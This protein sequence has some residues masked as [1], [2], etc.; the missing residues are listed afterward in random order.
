MKKKY[1]GTDGIRGRVGTEK[2]H[3]EF[4]MKLGWALGRVLNHTDHKKVIIG[5]DTRISGYMFESAL[6]AG[7]SAAGVDVRLIGPMPTPA[8][9]YLTQTFRANAGVVISASHNPYQD[10]GIKFFDSNG[11]KLPDEIE[12]AIEAEMAKPFELQEPHLLGKASRINDANGRYIEFCKST[13]SSKLRLNGLKIVLDCANGATYKVAP[14]VFKE[15]GAQVVVIG[16]KP[17]GLNINHEC[18]S[19]HPEHL[20]AK[21]LACQADLGIAFDGDGDRVVM[22]DHQGQLINGDGV[23]YLIATD[24]HEQKRLQGGVVGT[25]MT[26]MALEVKFKELQIPFIRSN[27]GDRYVLAELKK[28][29]WIIGGETSGHIVCLDKTTTGDGI[30]AALQV[31]ANMVREQKSL[32][33]LM[34]EIQFYPQVLLNIKTVNASVL[35]ESADVMHVIEKHVNALEGRGRILV[36]PSGTEPLLRIL[37]E[38]PNEA[39]LIER[40]NDIEQVVNQIKEN[41]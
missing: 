15:L 29:N 13:I 39:E 1:F 28:N 30:I 10:N 5:K 18:G 35:M 3:P 33:E 6:E 9:A 31:L 24:R 37:L 38:G 2:I 14:S 22:V 19:T 8:I 21:V 41:A 16:D 4:I 26:N 20:Q 27:V 40:K 23:L 12:L 32:A 25:L 36:R 11:E 34:S 7:F 17:D